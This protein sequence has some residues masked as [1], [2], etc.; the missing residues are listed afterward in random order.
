MAMNQAVTDIYARFGNTQ[1][2]DCHIPHSNKQIQTCKQPLQHVSHISSGEE[3]IPDPYN[4]NFIGKNLFF[5][6][7]EGFAYFILN[8]LFQYRF[9]LDHW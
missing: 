7:V 2:T 8:V 6:A 5:M 9:F 3:Y 4:W 1:Q